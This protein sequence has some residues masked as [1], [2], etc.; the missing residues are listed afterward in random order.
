MDESF[1]P[2]GADPELPFVGA[3]LV[4]QNVQTEID[5]DRARNQ[6]TNVK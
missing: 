5:Y 3:D 6:Q 4:A 2:S 1:E